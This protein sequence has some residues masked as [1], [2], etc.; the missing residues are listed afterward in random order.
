MTFDVIDRGFLEQQIDQAIE[1][2]PK[3][4][5][6][7]RD[8]LKTRYMIKNEH[9]FALGYAISQVYHIFGL[10]FLDKWNRR[11]TETEEDEITNHIDKRVAEMRDAIFNCG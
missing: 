3:I 2:I 9:D 6:S 7:L 1:G 11:P 8:N 5:K 4:M 10:Y